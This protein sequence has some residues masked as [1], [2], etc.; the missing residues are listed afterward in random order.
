MKRVILLLILSMAAG[1]A[2]ANLGERRIYPQVEPNYSYT[3]SRDPNNWWDDVNDVYTIN[4]LLDILDVNVAGDLDVNDVNIS[5]DLALDSLTASR[6]L[7]LDADNAVVS[8]L[9]LTDWIAGTAN[10]VIA[11]DDTD[12]TLTLSTPQDIHTAA[13]PTFAG[14]V[15]TGGNFSL[16]PS[17]AD[18]DI[19]ITFAG[20]TNSGVFK[21]MEDEDYFEFS[22]DLLLDTGIIYLQETTTP[23]A[24]ANHAALYTKNT[25]SLFFQDGAGSEHLIH[26]DAFSSLWFHNTSAATVTIGS[27]DTF[28]LIDAFNNVGDEDDEGNITGNTTTNEIT[29]GTNA[30]GEYDIDFH[31]SI[32]SAA[33]PSEMIVVAGIEFGTGLTIA[34]A[35]NANPIVITVTAGHGMLDGDMI[36]IAGCTG[37]TAADGDWHVTASDATTITLV[38]LSGANGVGNGAYNAD[39]GAITLCYPGNIL[40]HRAVSNTD[41][42]GGGSKGTRSLVATDKVAMYTVNLSAARDLQVAQINFEIERVAD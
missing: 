25:N 4:G 15:F 34:T 2:S 38:D 28:V 3:T 32:T 10:Q 7:A 31:A 40:I 14:L 9:D 6:L 29:L 13:T 26:G 11:T 27:A 12:G 36:T 19:T 21:W 23:G 35:T 16:T 17:T 5:G 1:Y 33:A 24:V 41:L 42:V 22:D 20:T 18:T 37:N 39:S 8:V 30:A